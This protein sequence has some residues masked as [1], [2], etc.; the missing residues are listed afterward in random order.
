LP[1]TIVF[2][3][4]GNVIFDGER[5]TYHWLVE[6]DHTRLQPTLPTRT[7]EIDVRIPDDEV[8]YLSR[9]GQHD[10]IRYDRE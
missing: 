2:S 6:S 4:D 9:A 1:K 7:F 8:L 3:A 10:N 5:G